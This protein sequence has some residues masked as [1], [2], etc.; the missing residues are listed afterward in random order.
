LTRLTLIVEQ[1]FRFVETLGVLAVSR[2]IFELAVWLRALA[3]DS[4]YG[5]SYYFQIMEKQI[6][7]YEDFVKRM[8]H[9]IALLKRFGEEERAEIEAMTKAILTKHDKDSTKA[10]PSLLKKI[11]SETDRKA[12]RN[13]CMYADQAKTNG[14]G[15]QAFLI[16]RQ[17]LLKLHAKLEECTKERAKRLGSVNARPPAGTKWEKQE[18]SWQWKQQAASVAGR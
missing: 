9:E 10:L 12:R 7:Y 16:E 3:Q 4:R 2:Y 13:F 18:Q 11:Q 15:F 6:R 8:E 14:H 17:I 1:N 5:L